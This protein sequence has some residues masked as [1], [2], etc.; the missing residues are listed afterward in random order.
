MTGDTAA[1]AVAAALTLPAWGYAVYEK[2]GAN[3]GLL[4]GVVPDGFSLGQNFP[5]PF[6][7]TT[8]ITY[9]LGALSE[10]RLTIYDLLG[11]EVQNLAMGPK[12]AGAY[13]VAFNATD[14]PSGE[15]IYQ[16]QAGNR[17][18]TKRLLLLR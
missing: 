1:F 12:H 6:N 5:N 10:P 13:E 11:R 7:S 8:R 16:L 2:N 18:E 14:L 17:M 9:S 15:Y 4:D 3:M